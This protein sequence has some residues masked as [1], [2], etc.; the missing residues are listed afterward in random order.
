MMA[1]NNKTRISDGVNSVRGTKTSTKSCI[2]NIT[3]TIYK[4]KNKAKTYFDEW[5]ERRNGM[6]QELNNLKT[7]DEV[8]EEIKEEVKTPSIEP[9]SIGS[10]V[11][12]IENN[13][14]LNIRKLEVY[15]AIIAALEDNDMSTSSIY[16]A[17]QN[18]P[19]IDIVGD[20]IV[21]YTKV[22]TLFDKL[23]IPCV[24]LA[25]YIQEELD[26][27]DLKIKFVQYKSVSISDYF[28]NN[29]FKI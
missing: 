27:D 12:M 8:V 5:F 4:S 21:I 1:K 25:S 24:N 20:V 15:N 19:F 7:E 26:N 2:L 18:I 3:P 22:P 9:S 14:S 28:I 29:K 13:D 6:L 11:L 10:D 23:Q 16:I 17:L